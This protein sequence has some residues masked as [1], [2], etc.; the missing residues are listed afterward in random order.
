MNKIVLSIAIIVC[1]LLSGCSTILSERADLSKTA[2][3]IRIFPP[4]IY[5]FVNN[6]KKITQIYI[7]PDP[8][9]A[10]DIKPLTILAKQEFTLEL[11]EGMLSKLI[12][13]QDTTAFI[14]LIKLAATKDAKQSSV[15]A[16][17]ALTQNSI[18]GTFG[19]SDG[20]YVFSERGT[21]L[22]IQ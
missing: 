10:Y 15:P 1:V 9:N 11:N 6:E 16:A 20:I 2:N 18:D 7:L 13:N 22:K 5:F 3:G 19:L 4:K 21:L 17:G 12:A 14:E 8:T